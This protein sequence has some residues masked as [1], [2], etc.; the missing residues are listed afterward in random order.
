MSQFP[1]QVLKN[2]FGEVSN[3]FV[4]GGSALTSS[5]VVDSTNGNGLGIRSLKGPGIKAVYMHTSATPAAGN[6][7][8]AVGF[9]LV[10]FAVGY[11]G[12]SGGYAGFV[13]PVSGTPINVTA[14]V[15]AGTTYVITSVGTT[16]AAQWQVLGVPATIT[17]A[18][19]VAFIA[20]A[21]TTATGTGV[22]EV[23]A[24][25]G[26]GISVVDVIGD[27]NQT[28]LPLFGGGYM[29]LRCM[30]GSTLAAAA[31]AD[32]SV[33]GIHTVMLEAPQSLI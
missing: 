24:A 2:Q 17:P 4:I 1:S 12:Y 13:S 30:N 21:S 11:S 18:V 23:P 7:N 8:P 14:G 9:I 31:P 32:G 16:S 25:A 3:N 29:V 10:E 22:V 26:S 5:F 28:S 15:T 33:V 20:I 19:G 6:P 27:P